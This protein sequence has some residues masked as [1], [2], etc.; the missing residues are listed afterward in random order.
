[1][2]R[3]L[4]C[5]S[6]LLCSALVL[7]LLVEQLFCCVSSSTVLGI[8]SLFYT[9]YISQCMQGYIVSAVYAGI[10]YLAF[11]ICDWLPLHAGMVCLTSLA[12][13]WPTSCWDSLS[14][15]LN[16]GIAIWLPWPLF[17]WLHAGIAW[18]HIACWDSMSMTHAILSP[19]PWLVGY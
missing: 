9:S 16:A 17:G 5:C 14:K 18:L 10:A 3:F 11:L 6:C 15:L 4:R 19:N 1:M 13:D 8:C 2:P 7:V 12:S